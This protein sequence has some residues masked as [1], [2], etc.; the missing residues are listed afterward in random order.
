[1]GEYEV[2]GLPLKQLP[3]MLSSDDDCNT[4]LVQRVHAHS[5]RRLWNESISFPVVSRYL[6]ALLEL[7]AACVW[8]YQPG[9]NH[10]TYF[11]ELSVKNPAIP[12]TLPTHLHVMVETICAQC[13]S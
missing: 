10:S 3:I 13:S 7:S 2:G 11:D 8:H 9:D 5:L 12:D 1:M 6:Q 4:R